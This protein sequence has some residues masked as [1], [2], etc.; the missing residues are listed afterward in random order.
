M[1]DISR[2]ELDRLYHT[3]DL[4]FQGVHSRLDT[5]NSRTG[6]AELAIAVLQDRAELNKNAIASL[7][8]RAN[9]HGAAA[10]LGGG[11]ASVVVGIAE[12]LKWWF[13]R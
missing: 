3:L 12:G 11:M 9:G 2:E 5:L 8:E 10:I 13:S 1:A 6:K 7:Q 4:G